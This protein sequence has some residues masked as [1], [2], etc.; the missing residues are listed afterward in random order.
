VKTGGFLVSVLQPL[1]WSHLVED[2]RLAHFLKSPIGAS[3]WRLYYGPAGKGEANV[4]YIAIGR[5][6]RT[7]CKRG[8]RSSE[9]GIV[10]Q[11]SLPPQ[12]WE[13][14]QVP[15]Q[16]DT[17][18][19]NLYYNKQ[20]GCL[21]LLAQIYFLC[22]LVNLL[23]DAEN[24]QLRFTVLLVILESAALGNVVFIWS[25]KHLTDNKQLGVYKQ[26]DLRR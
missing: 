19:T 23:V 10:P 5:M 1:G 9:P 22:L 25:A 17:S 14:K 16:D 24:L 3:H 8:W 26:A 7:P 11:I 2:A 15:T 20:T 13:N 21:D 18:D 4:L 6:R 12:A